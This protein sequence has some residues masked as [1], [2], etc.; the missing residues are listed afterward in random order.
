MTRLSDLKEGRGF[1]YN[2]KNEV[3]EKEKKGLASQPE[4]SDQCPGTALNA[5]NLSIFYDH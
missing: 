3:A 5:Y 2:V 4:I 1:R